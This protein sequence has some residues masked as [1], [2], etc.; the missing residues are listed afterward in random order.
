[1]LIASP[2]GVR[3]YPMAR[4]FSGSDTDE[5][6]GVGAAGGHVSGGLGDVVPASEFQEADCE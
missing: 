2:T 4:A 3:A 6:R 1:M 5:A